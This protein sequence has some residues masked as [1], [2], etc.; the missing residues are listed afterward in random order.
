MVR[1]ATKQDRLKQSCTV[2]LT[3]PYHK[4]QS[5][6]QKLAALQ[7]HLKDVDDFNVA[8]TAEE[9]ETSLASL[10]GKQAALWCPSGTMA[11]GIAAHVYADRRANN[12]LILHKT[13]HLLLHEEDGYSALHGLAA[14][15]VGAWRGTIKPD[16]L[17]RDAACAFIEMPQRHSGGL[18]PTWQELEALK[19]KAASLELPL[20]MDGARIWS[21]RPYYG[22]R[23]F[24]EISEGIS[25]LYVSFYKDIGA[26]SG[27]ALIGDKD[28]INEARL[29]LARMGGWLVDAS[30]LQADT[31]RLLDKRLPQMPDF[32]SK[33]QAMAAAL[34]SLDN[35]SISPAV[36]QINMFHIL[37]PCSS[38]VA[39]RARDT[40]AEKLGTWL[41]NRFWNYE[42]ETMCA[43][44]VTVGEKALD[45]PL[46]DYQQA[47]AL[48][49]SE[50]NNNT[51]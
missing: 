16:M 42:S 1:A 8:A 37:L 12:K 21:C 30:F 32:V 20:H 49:I 24:A 2:D 18:L 41:S 34:E 25:S 46:A 19:A 28:F 26:S 50:I 17:T 15:E 14:L 33:A 6:P 38:S 45:L 10:F 51:Q 4:D 3:F 44:E 11:Q 9:L 23:S 43:M 31:L 48:L 35:L 39:E 13:S 47:V 40:V 7:G 5:L 29:W 22:D 27:A 36:P